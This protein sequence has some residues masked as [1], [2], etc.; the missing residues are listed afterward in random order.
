MIDGLITIARWDLRQRLRSRRLLVGWLIWVGVLTALAGFVVWV[1]R[2]NSY[3]SQDWARQSGPAVFGMI[4]LLM[5]SF[6]LVV[7]PI[8]SASAIVTER[9]SATLATLQATTLR[10]GQIVGGKLA[11]AC[12][13]AAG[14]M[15]GGVPALIIAIANGHMSIGRAAS[16]LLVMYAE[17]VFL[18]AIALGWSAIATRALVSTVMTYLTVFTLTIVTLIMFGLLAATATTRE[19]FRTWGL[20]PEQRIAYSLQLGQYF[21]EHPDDDGTLAPAPPLDKCQ[22]GDHKIREQVHFEWFWWLLLINPFV[23]VS[24]AAPLPAWAEGDIEEYTSRSGFDP[25]AMIAFAVRSARLGETTETDDCFTSST[26]ISD[27]FADK[28]YFEVKPNKD[29]T[30]TVEN[31]F[32]GAQNVRVTEPVTHPPS[33]VPPHRVTIDTPLWPIGLAANL[34]IAAW[35]YVIALRRVSVPY[36]PLPK[37]QRVA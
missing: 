34:A 37:G 17:M 27:P 30:F 18:S 12:V 9:E 22:W 33:P 35:F 6:A 36:G 23:I 15:A 5:L 16:C 26:F 8:F 13:V 21:D 19:E 31:W 14:F 1:W 4:V 10:P 3:P 11:S 2:S 20:P 29:G 7:V 24:D 28:D 25:L 32:D